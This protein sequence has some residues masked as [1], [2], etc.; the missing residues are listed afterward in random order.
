MLLRCSKV[1]TTNEDRQMGRYT[2][3]MANSNQPDSENPQNMSTNNGEPPSVPPTGGPTVL[4]TVSEPIVS[5]VSLMLTYSIAHTRPI[6]NFTGPR[7]PPQTSP[8]IGTSVFRPFMPPRFL[9][10]SSGRDQP[11]GMPTSM[12]AYLQSAPP[13]F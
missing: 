3:E 4:A 8:P 1:T 12:M 6:L 7:S 2:R 10:L 11:Y 9:M 13:V 5:M